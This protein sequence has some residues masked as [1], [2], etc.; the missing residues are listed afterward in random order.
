MRREIREEPEEVEPESK[1]ED[2]E[3]EGPFDVDQYVATEVEELGAEHEDPALED[4]RFFEDEVADGP[5][6]DDVPPPEVGERATGSR[7]EPAGWWKWLEK[8]AGS[9]GSRAQALSATVL[10]QA[11]GVELPGAPDSVLKRIATV[12][13]IAL[14]SLAVGA[15]TYLLGKGSGADVEQA[16]LEGTAA[17]REAG[18]IEGAAQG[19]AAGFRRGREAGFR[20]AYVPAYR[21]YYK[22]AFEQAGLDVPT[23]KEIDVPLP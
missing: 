23:N 1:F 8:R 21:L 19:Y 10:A 15:G 11:R 2:D 17:G 13:A 5:T 14:A 7:S 18:A 4:P 12:A 9:V 6:V 3:L 22:R 20:N 16:R